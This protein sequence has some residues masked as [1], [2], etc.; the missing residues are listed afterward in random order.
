MRSIKSW[1]S[2]KLLQFTVLAYAATTEG[3]KRVKSHPCGPNVVFA[4]K[5]P[6]IFSECKPAGSVIKLC[7]KYYRGSKDP[8][9][10]NRTGALIVFKHGCPNNVPPL[11]HEAHRGWKPLFDGRSGV[12]GFDAITPAFGGLDFSTYLNAMGYSDLGRKRAFAELS[13]SGKRLALLM[14]AIKKGTTRIETLC[15]ATGLPISEIE[16]LR[17]VAIKQKLL[18]SNFR[19]TDLGLGTLGSIL[20]A[21][22]AEVLPKKEETYYYPKQLRLPFQSI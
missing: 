15:S 20:K 6:T 4:R 19:L 10:Y 18:A 2:R 21:E 12:F 7:K 13:E 3:I 14:C 9:G 22:V 11:F 1:R 16:D 8:I 17:K 5:C